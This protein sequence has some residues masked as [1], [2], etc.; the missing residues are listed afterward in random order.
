[1]GNMK[2]KK[3]M[4]LSINTIIIAALGLIVLVII[5]FIFRTQV[6]EYV[7]GYGETADKAIKSADENN[8]ER[9][10]ADVTR[11]CSANSLESE[12][13]WTEIPGKKCP[14]N[15]KCYEYAKK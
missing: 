10:F 7:R 14:T 12:T 3:A 13:D 5:A 9:L 4:G 8:C 11:K 1:M 6:G 2:H 15:Q